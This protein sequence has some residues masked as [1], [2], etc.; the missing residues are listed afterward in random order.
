VR[1]PCRTQRQVRRPAKANSRNGAK[2]APYPS[3]NIF[4]AVVPPPQPRRNGSKCGDF[5]RGQIYFPK[6]TDLF[7]KGDR[8]FPKGTDLFSKG[9]RFIFQRGQIYFPKGT[10]LF[11]KGDRFIWQYAK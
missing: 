1:Y 8:Y 6:G 9:D 5:Q 4:P 10:D 2:P 11:S 7:S 3:D